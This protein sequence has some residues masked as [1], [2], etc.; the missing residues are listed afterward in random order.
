MSSPPAPN[1]GSNRRDGPPQTGPEDTRHPA[2]A[3][4]E[5]DEEEY[6]TEDTDDMD[7]FTRA[8]QEMEDRADNESPPMDEHYGISNHVLRFYI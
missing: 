6:G 8:I 5:E 3:W 2:R 1:A 4:L 7:P